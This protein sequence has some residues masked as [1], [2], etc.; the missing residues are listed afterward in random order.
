MICVIIHLN[1]KRRQATMP[2]L[3]YWKTAWQAEKANSFPFIRTIR[4]AGKY[5]GILLSIFRLKK[6]QNQKREEGL[7]YFPWD[8]PISLDPFVEIRY[9]KKKGGVCMD[10]PLADRL[11]P[12]TLDEVVGQSHLIGG[13]KIISRLVSSGN[14]PNM[15]FYGPSGTGKPRLPISLPEWPIKSSINWTRKTHLLPTSSTL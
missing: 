6:R 13:G 4:P 8:C 15:I 7:R 12:A 10:R 11:R 9:N 2:V 1:W 5:N 3:K 14:M